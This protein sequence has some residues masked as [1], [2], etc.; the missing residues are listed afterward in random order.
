MTVFGPTATQEIVPAAP[1]SF[2]LE[3]ELLMCNGNSILQREGSSGR[4][5]PG[6]SPSHAPA[7][8]CSRLQNA[9]KSLQQLSAIRLLFVFEVYLAMS[10]KVYSLL[11][12]KQSASSKT[13]M[14]HCLYEGC[15]IVATWLDKR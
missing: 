4:S 7:I 15:Q 5:V 11:A 9:H 8:P 1:A 14:M 13:M 12:R 6:V 10:S 3:L 2:T